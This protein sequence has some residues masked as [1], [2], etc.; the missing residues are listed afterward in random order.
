MDNL[1]QLW[2]KPQSELESK[3]IELRQYFQRTNVQFRRGDD[4]MKAKLATPW[5]DAL[6]N[7][8]NVTW[9]VKCKRQAELSRS[10]QDADVVAWLEYVRES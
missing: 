8:W 2:A 6:V 3:V 4:L 10:Q 5:A 7:L 9:I 1:L